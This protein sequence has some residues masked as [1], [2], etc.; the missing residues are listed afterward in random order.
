MSD[1]KEMEMI[2]FHKFI[3]ICKSYWNTRGSPI[4]FRNLV[5][6]EFP[7]KD[8]EFFIYIFIQNVGSNPKEFYKSTDEY[9]LS[10]ISDDPSIM[11]AN[12]DLNN[13]SIVTGARKIIQMIKS[14]SFDSL[15]VYSEK[16]AE[17]ALNALIIILTND[18]KAEL[19]KDIFTI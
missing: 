2:K 18:N 13:P 3:E 10:I 1:E 5:T 9:M 4:E 14:D 19:K 12:L 11:L 15:P 7:P 6:K 17:S 8:I 16:S